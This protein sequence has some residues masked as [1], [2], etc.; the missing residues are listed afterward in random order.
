MKRSY[1]SK[2]PKKQI[3]ILPQKQ[4]ESQ[5][6]NITSLCDGYAEVSPEKVEDYKSVY[7]YVNKEEK[8]LFPFIYHELY[9]IHGLSERVII[10]IKRNEFIKIKEGKKITFSL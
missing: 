6:T 10:N 7:F 9:K 1:K 4:T 5:L 2:K 8:T 3:K